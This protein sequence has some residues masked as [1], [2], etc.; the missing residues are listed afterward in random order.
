MRVATRSRNHRSWLITTGVQPANLHR[1]RPRGR[2][3]DV[4]V[5]RR[6]VE[7]EDVRTA[8]QHAGQVHA[9]ALASGERVDELLLILPGEAEAGDEGAEFIFARR[10]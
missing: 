5:V 8:P 2:S 7:Q 3:V 9:V 4:D 6:L 10:A 1:A